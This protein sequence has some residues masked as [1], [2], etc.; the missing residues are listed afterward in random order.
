M[1]ELACLKNLEIDKLLIVC[2]LDGTL[3]NENREV[4]PKNKMALERFVEK[5]GHFTIATGR[6]LKGA[7]KILDIVP[8]NMPIILMNGALIYDYKQNEIL[9]ECTLDKYAQDIIFQVM[10][11][12]PDIGVEIFNRNEISLIREN[13][14]TANHILRES[15][16]RAYNEAK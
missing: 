15:F 12:F 6:N 10:G 7:L 16:F 8:V 5:G 14:V 3:L 1:E 11:E 9:Y 2:D 13:D 4:S